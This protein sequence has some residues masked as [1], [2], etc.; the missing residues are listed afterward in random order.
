MKPEMRLESQKPKLHLSLRVVVRPRIRLIAHGPAQA[1]QLDTIM[2]DN[3]TIERDP[4]RGRVVKIA[5]V[6]IARDEI[7]GHIEH[8][9]NIFKVVQRQVAAGNHQI[10]LP[11][12][13]LL[14]STVD[15]R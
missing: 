13:V 14:Q 15:N 8:A 1:H 10:D 11:E 5:L 7:T 12:R 3:P 2:I 9:D 4:A 6:M